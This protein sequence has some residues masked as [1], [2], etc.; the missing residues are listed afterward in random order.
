MWK[1]PVFVLLTLLL[2][3][4]S[5]ASLRD[6]RSHGFYRFF[7]WEAILAIILLN[8]NVWISNWLAWYQIISWFLLIVC[9]LPLV[10]GIHHLRSRG[11]PDKEKRLEPPLLGFERTTVLVTSGVYHFIRHPLY[12][13]LLLLNWGVFFKLPSLPGILLA[14]AATFFLILTSK[15]D[16]AECIRTFGRQYQDYMKTTKM[17]IPLIY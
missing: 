3:Y 10:L 12:S 8:L 1:I 14:I 4:I 13:S 15:A 17:F 7:A 2:G 6:Q 16:E 5:R 11:L 9:I